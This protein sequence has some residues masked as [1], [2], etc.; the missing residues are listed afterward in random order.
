MDSKRLF[1]KQKYSKYSRKINA[2]NL[3][4]KD[5]FRRS[6]QKPLSISS[7]VERRRFEMVQIKLASPRTI[8]Q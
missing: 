7:N 5:L 2:H 4:H 8:L 1:L 6:S 3:K